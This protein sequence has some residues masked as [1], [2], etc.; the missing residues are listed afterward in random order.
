MISD[1]FKEILDKYSTE[2][3]KPFENNIFGL[4]M[5]NEFNNDLKNFLKNNIQNFDEYETMLFRGLMNAWLKTPWAGIRNK[6]TAQ[7]F[8]KGIFIIYEFDL[9]NKGVLLSINQGT[10]EK[11]RKKISLKILTSRAKKLSD[12]IVEKNDF[13]S[14]EKGKK[15]DNLNL[16]SKTAII[17]KYYHYNELNNEILKKDLKI[18]INIYEKIIPYYINLIN[19]QQEH[20]FD[21]FKN[22]PSKIKK[23]EEMVHKG[24]NNNEIAKEFET[25]NSVI[26][27]V[28]LE[29]TNIPP[30]ARGI[31]KGS[32][33]NE[34]ITTDVQTLY[35]NVWLLS[36]GEVAK[37][38]NEFRE[39]N[40]VAIGWGEL[41]DLSKYSN[42][43][44]LQ[45]DLEKKYPKQNKH[46]NASNSNKAPKQ[47]NNAKAL[48]DFYKKMKPGDLVF[49]KKGI[50]TLL[51]LGVITSDYKFLKDSI[52]TDSDYNNVRDV[53]WL[54][55]GEF[56][57]LDSFGQFTQKTLTNIT[58]IKYKSF[59]GSEFY[60]GLAKIMNFSIDDFFNKHQKP[61][62][63][64]EIE[65]KKLITLLKE[66]NLDS[67][68]PDLHDG[69]YKL[70]DKAVHYLSKINPSEYDNKDMD[71]LYLMT[72]G[73]W[74]HGWDKKK[75]RIIESNLKQE[76]KDSL[77]QILN[78][79]KSIAENKGYFNSLEN[80]HV[81]MFGTGF[82]KF[83]KLQKE[84]AQK[85]IKMCVEIQDIENQNEVFTKTNLV[86][87]DGI[88]GMGIAS[89]SQIL[90]CL[91]PFM[92]PIINSAMNNNS[93]VY[94]ILGMKLEKPVTET[95]YIIKLKD[96]ILLKIIE[97]LI[98]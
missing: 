69:S 27:R 1:D 3:N 5:D 60:E 19:N 45:I 25:T 4:K 20:N 77:I 84:D 53:E 39:G 86:L 15:F 66:I 11:N 14:H 92:F 26:S 34:L 31:K 81:G 24:S 55:I 50:K 21:W 83:N 44:E 7:N 76:D 28:R 90:H 6:K 9:K 2:T 78:D 80:N 38:W 57:L 17:S 33:N 58:N 56:N 41:G 30:H 72:V 82:M 49:I 54:K 47:T 18:L 88:K 71:M 93:E 85:F 97:H 94:D 13:L 87:K 16:G 22:N 42:T 89:V 75:N 91:K 37:Y 61:N 98:Y 36:P 29:L 67:Y 74:S 46:F 63:L 79:V 52:I 68:N 73:T 48:Y 12:R 64:N 65:N 96:L 10:N 8:S 32:K 59:N 43:K 95:N 70:V 51:G 35:Q 62:S 23:V 40:F